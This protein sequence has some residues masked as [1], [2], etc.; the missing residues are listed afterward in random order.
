[1]S[2]RPSA[3]LIAGLPELGRVTRGEIAALVGV[4]PFARESGR[5]RGKRV[6]RG[7]RKDLRN[8]L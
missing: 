8:T 4:A 6:C 5:W 1:M 2:L 3:A 7:G